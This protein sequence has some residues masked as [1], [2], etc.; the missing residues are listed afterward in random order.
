[1]DEHIAGLTETILLSIT[2]HTI[3]KLQKITRC[4]PNLHEICPTYVR[5]R[6]CNLFFKQI[7]ERADGEEHQHKYL[8][9]QSAKCVITV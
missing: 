9:I 7:E 3:D 6:I 5:V 2:H 8:T 1:M 4:R